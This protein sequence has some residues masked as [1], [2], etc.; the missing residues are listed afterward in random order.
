MAVTT[1]LLSRIQFAFTISFHILFPAFSIGLVTFLTVMEG[2]W[3]KTKNPHYLTLC[4]F[5]TKVFALTF[6]MGI[7]SGVVMEFQFGTN[8]S[9]F[10][11]AVGDVLGALFTYEV[12]T[13]FFIEAGAVGVMLFGWERVG[14]RLH[15]FS[16]VLVFI[17]VTLSAFWILSANSWMQT[18]AGAKYV[19]GKFI[20]T[21]WFKVVFNPL[22]IPRY[23]HMLMAAYIST[24][25]VIISVCAY[26][27]RNNSHLAF[28]KKCFSF[29]IISL[30][31]LMPLQIFIGDTVGL[32][33]HKYQPI[34][35]AAME[36]VWNTQRGAPFVLFAIPDPKAQ[37][38]YWAIKIPHAAALINTHQWNG[39][40]RG[41]KSVPRSQQPFVPA[42]FF[43]FRIMVGL[44][45]LM[46]LV[47]FSGC[48]L[49]YRK[50]LFA[51]QR[52]LQICIY[53]APL[54]FIALWAGWITAEMG[55]QPW[56]VYNYIRTIDAASQVSPFH[57]GF[58][59]FLLFV[60]Y[61]IIFGYFFT[62]YLLKLIQ[63]GP[64]DMAETH[65]PFAYLGNQAVE[66][67]S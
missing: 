42:V 24:G 14:H 62:R 18:P 51:S 16:T 10:T 49:L 21:D 13:A 4:K 5:W 60:V 52:F 59:F 6:G 9:G 43:S 23:L 46:L 20:A 65:E 38:N 30:A 32:N 53:T 19:Q 44:G 12:L 41:L 40:L 55:R 11:D 3:L 45:M 28:A 57:V 15:Y 67:K 22:V 36:G 39:Q 1:E 2:L 7:V 64:Q 17:G 8:W 35:T 66:K 58:S 47:A 25:F 29:V 48:Y 26:Y 34:K 63:H 56:I 50:K 37:K 27:L 61:G 33:V 54:G 31:I